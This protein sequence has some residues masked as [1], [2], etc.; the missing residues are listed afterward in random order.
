MKSFNSTI[1]TVFIAVLFVVI[2]FLTYKL[3]KKGN[4][5]QTT[6]Y[7]TQIQQLEQDISLKELEINKLTLVSDSLNEVTKTLHSVNDSLNKQ[8]QKVKI[9]YAD[10]YKKIVTAEHASL[11]SIIRSNW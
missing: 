7:D 11:D 4:N 10:K 3:Y 1:A 5:P 6:S 9:V 2:T 8:K